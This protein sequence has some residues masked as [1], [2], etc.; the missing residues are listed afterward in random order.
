M[1]DESPRKAEAFEDHAG[2][3]I[4]TSISPA[5]DTSAPP[6][7]EPRTVKRARMTKR[8]TAAL[9]DELLDLIASA[10]PP[11]T[12]RQVDYLAVGR[13]LL[14]SKDDKGYRKIVRR[15]S[16]MRENGSC[17]WEWIA[18]STRWVRRHRS[19]GDLS[20]ALDEV[21]ASYRRDYWRDQ[22]VR[23]ELWVE[24]DALASA[25]NRAVSGFGVPMFVCRGQASKAYIYQAAQDAEE[26]GKPVRVLYLGDFDP[27]GLQIDRSMQERYRRY[28][29][30]DLALER[31]AVTPQQIRDMKLQ[32]TDAKRGDPNYKRFASICEA[33]DLPVRA[34]E[35][36]AID[37]PV[38][39]QLTAD[40]IAAHIDFDR[41]ES[42][43]SYERAE[44]QTLAN[45]LGGAA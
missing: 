33:Q 43:A 8:E 6:V 29:A 34:W 41:W 4:E 2:D 18:D 3:E 7:Y 28:G 24:S 1:N 13:G 11:V 35:A 40:A 16:A 9:D 26:I 31:I 37:P 42:T 21:Q 15:L 25:L 39:R 27:T 5:G 36:E 44:R 12:V 19:Y 17:P 30:T 23:L 38:L 32:S 14:D 20:E 22:P 45:L 10:G